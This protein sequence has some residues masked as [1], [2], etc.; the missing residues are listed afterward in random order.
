MTFLAPLF[1]I[2][3]LAGVIPVVLH[4]IN[5]R[6]AKELPFSTLRFL[7]ISVE[8]TRRRKRVHD[9]LLMLVRVAVLVLIALGLA[10]PTITNLSALWGGGTNTAVAI[11][12]DNSASMGEIDPDR[13]RFDT[14]RGAAVQV[15]D[16]LRDGDQV[17][18]FLTGGAPF[19][20]QGQLDRTHEKVRQML[21]TCEVSYERADLGTKV[22]QAR[23]VLADSDAANRQIYVISDQ[24]AVSW[25]S[26]KAESE[27]ASDAGEASDEE[28]AELA[29]P[30]IVVD[31]HR[32]PKPNVAVQS[33]KLEASVPV[34]GLPVKATAEL[35]NASSIAQQRHLELVVDGTKTASSPAL[36][37]PPGGRLKHDFTFTLDRGGLH[38]G[39][40]RLVGKDGSALDDRRFFTIEIDRGIAVAVVKARKHEIPYLEDTFY[41][42]QALSPGQSGGSAIRPTVLTADELPGEPLSQYRVVFCVNLPAPGAEAAE[43]LRRY[44]AD[45]GNLVWIAGDNVDPAAYNSMN[46]AA[47]GNL[48]PAALVDVR[49]AAGGSERDSW[50]VGFLDK[51]HPALGDL[52]E[53]ASLYQSVLVYRHVRMDTAGSP[54]A[55]VLAR[56]DDGEALLAERSVDKGRVLMLA[57]SAHVGW[58]NLPLRP[59]FLPLVVRL[60]FWLS[61]GEQDRRE[62][63]AGSPLV[64]ELDGGVAAGQVG[65][66]VQPPSGEIIR[67]NT[68]GTGGSTRQTFS[69]PDT[70]QIGI[71]QLRPLGAAGAAPIA[72]SVNVDPDEA[73]EKTMDRD[74]LQQRFGRTPLV[75]ADNPDDLSGTFAW[76]REGE[77]LWELFL[78]AVLVVLVFE[79]YVSNRLGTAGASGGLPGSVV[80]E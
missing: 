48:L 29:I 64:L 53:P 3:A 2:G 49:A 36:E 22:Q 24:Q 50:K 11:I 39:E 14:A 6:K 55:R 5:R 43:R 30:I 74:E 19:P 16:Q 63:L 8:K 73:E 37:L 71:Y 18:L 33:V 41:V 20:E 4:M 62:V 52:V 66:E 47:Q 10:K 79:T 69:Y 60:T 44:V 45:G 7:R 40:V 78:G 70:H 25:E 46:A 32:T 1:L 75:F 61:G 57:T 26:Q 28:K 31:C 17:A 21:A 67:L 35:L 15:M 34:A 72:F 51:E 77:S 59:I 9:L 68:E 12:L 56:L 13:P 38:R 80:A 58:T 27:P 23:R 65:V 76:L 54:D 42:E